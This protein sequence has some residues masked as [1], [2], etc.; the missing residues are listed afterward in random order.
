MPEH[1]A[2]SLNCN[3]K[4]TQVFSEN[5]YSSRKDSFIIKN[6]DMSTHFLKPYVMIILGDENFLLPENSMKIIRDGI[7]RTNTVF[8]SP[9]DQTMTSSRLFIPNVD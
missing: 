2:I 3:T 9:F 1:N 4:N 8:P 6:S 5:C 7:S